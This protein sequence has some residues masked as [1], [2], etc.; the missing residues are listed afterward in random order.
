VIKNVALLRSAS[1]CAIA[2]AP[3]V[4]TSAVSVILS[5]SKDTRA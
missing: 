3:S 5:L 2:S 1:V 4:I